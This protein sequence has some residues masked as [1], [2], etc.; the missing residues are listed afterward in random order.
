MHLIPYFLA[1]EEGEA[2]RVQ[3]ERQGIGGAWIRI[4]LWW[5]WS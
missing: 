5:V 4:T 3:R 2:G 1:G